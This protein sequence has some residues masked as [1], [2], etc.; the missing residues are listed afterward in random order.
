MIMTIPSQ[1]IEWL[2]F[3]DGIA[4][5]ES[6]ISKSQTQL[7]RTAEVA[8]DLGLTKSLTE[9]DFK[10][11]GSKMESAAIDLKKRKALA[12]SAFWVLE[13]LWSLQI[14]ISAKYNL[15]YTI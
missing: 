12:R 1:D 11:L 3:E 10:Y 15:L 8:K 5:F 2:E 14:T 7:T 6:F 13:R 4:L 9:T